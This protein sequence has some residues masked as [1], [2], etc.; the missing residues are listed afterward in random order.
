MNEIEIIVGIII[1]I[2]IVI[3]FRHKVSP[4]DSS[5]IYDSEED[6]IIGREFKQGHKTWTDS[7]NQDF[8]KDPNNKR[9]HRRWG[10]YN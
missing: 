3:K 2:I 7:E 8:L 9:F 6:E 10:G 4:L 5:W 1:V